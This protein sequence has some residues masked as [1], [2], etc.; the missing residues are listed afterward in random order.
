MPDNG[1][2]PQPQ[3][4]DEATG[5]PPDRDF[6][7]QDLGRRRPRTQTPEGW[8]KKIERGDGKV[9]VG[10]F[11]VWVTSKDGERLRRKK[12]KVLGPA[13]IPK[14]EALKK[15][16][17][18]VQTFTHEKPAETTVIRTYADLWRTFS[19]LK[20]GQWSQP[21]RETIR[22][23]FATHVLPVIGKQWLEEISLSTLQ[24]LVNQMAEDGYSKSS[25]R[26]VRLYLKAS[27]DYAAD[28]DLVA[29]N[30]ARKLAMPKIRKTVCRRYLSMEEIGALL[31]Q[32]ETRE[33][34]VLHILAA[35]GLRPAEI[36]VLRIEDFAGN[37]L[38]IDEALKDR[39]KGNARIGETKTEASNSSVPVPPNLAREI[40]QW[41][42]RHPERMNPRAFLFPSRKKTP[43][44]VGNYL[45]RFLKPLAHK[46]GIEDLTHQALRRTS[47]THLQKYASVKD[48][49]AHLRHTNPQTTLTYYTQ[50]IPDSLCEAVAT[51]DEHLR[52]A[53]NESKQRSRSLANLR[54][55]PTEAEVQ[56]P[57]L[58][59]VVSIE[60]WRKRPNPR[61]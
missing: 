41:I 1:T 32:A 59:R 54:E 16:A 18:Y 38:R 26:K 46:V 30:P 31:S 28:E 21:F 45:K 43:Y 12:E 15:L 29:K 56:T 4:L 2:R 25:V 11:H 36:L 20:S 23:V 48:L 49:Q 24:L 44:S 60:G 55:A 40:A 22:S 19:G 27:F 61:I 42:A 17:A 51:L 58:Q 8:V 47:S 3:Q 7:V 52:A 35:C 6:R 5:T 50:V 39:E 13:A 57:A 14:H 9:W 34:L 33:H 37:Q 10:F 53:A